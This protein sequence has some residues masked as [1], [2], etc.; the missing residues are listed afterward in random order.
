MKYIQCY[1]LFFSG[2]LLLSGCDNKQNSS[3]QISKK[4]IVIATSGEPSPFTTVNSKGEL[5]GY[6]IDV[7]KA[8]FAELPQYQISFEI[9]EFTSVLA[10]LD[11]DRYQVGANNFA[12]NEQRKEKYFYTDPIFLN[13]Y[14]IAVKSDDN[15]INSFKDLHGKSTETTPGL[16]YSTALEQYNQQN[17]N[18]PINIDYSEADLLALL[19]HVESGKYDFQLVDRA[20]L[21]QFID[22]HQLKLKSIEL[23]AEDSARIGLPYSYLLVS[24]SGQG[25]QLTQDLNQ[26]IK[27]IIHNGKLAEISYHYFNAD[28]SP[29]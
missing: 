26:G 22:Q 27:N 2:L 15:R 3:E 18:N 14:V 10:G 1:L 5:I 16:N 17:P 25:E 9:T 7:V 12:M 4:K 21:Q 11:A 24:K 19:Q 20:M 8:I 13:Q 6:D 28:Y 29:K 23:S